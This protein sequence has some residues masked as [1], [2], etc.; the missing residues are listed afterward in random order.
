M[1]RLDGR[2]DVLYAQLQRRMLEHGEWHRYIT[3]GSRG[4]RMVV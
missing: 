3:K 2:H 1:A 4:Q